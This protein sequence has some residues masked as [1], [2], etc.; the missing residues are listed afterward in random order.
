[1][2]QKRRS[3]GILHF[4]R[5][6]TLTIMRKVYIA[7]LAAYLYLILKVM[8][9]KDIPEFR[10]GRTR[11]RLGGTDDGPPNWIPFRSIRYYLIGRYGF[12]KAVINLVGNVALLVPVGYLA[13]AIQPR[14]TWKGS[15]AMGLAVSFTI[16]AI[17]GLF[18][19]G[20]VDVDDIILNTAGVMAGQMLFAWSA[21]RNA[22]R[23]LA[24]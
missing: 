23:N 22:T 21:R 11:W 15:M 16:E 1:M 7:L 12:G 13:A 14:M 8:V 5:T 9:L 20:I 18:R 10:I 19:L 24:P 17:Q 4:G 6:H 3:I 2:L